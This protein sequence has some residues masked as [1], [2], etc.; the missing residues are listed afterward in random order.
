MIPQGVIV[1]AN[2][3]GMPV[4]YAV[5]PAAYGPSGMG[6][7]G[8][9]AYPSAMLPG[10]AGGIPPSN[11]AGVTAPEWGMPIT[12]TPIGLPG[13]AHIPFGHQAGLRHHAIHNHTHVELP[14]PTSHLRFDVKQHPKQSY[15]AS[16]HRT[17]VY[18]K[19]EFPSPSLYQPHADTQHCL[20]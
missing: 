12:S 14:Q 13:P 2:F 10:G 15:P 19:S 6:H 8:A 20:P 7:L 16:P 11:V 5:S 9:A 17:W 3:Q 4:P 1:P 18:E